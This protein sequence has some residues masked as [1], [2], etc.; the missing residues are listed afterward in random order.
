M[1]QANALFEY[2][3]EDEADRMKFEAQIHGA[4]IEDKGGKKMQQ[5]SATATKTVKSDTLNGDPDM[6]FKDP[7]DYSHMSKEDR[8][9]LTQKMMGSFKA[10]SRNPLQNQKGPPK[11]G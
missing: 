9:Q 5:Q 1:R 4:T 11:F 6:L 7:K 8:E 2:A 10:W 3:Q